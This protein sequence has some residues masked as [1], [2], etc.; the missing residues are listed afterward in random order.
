MAT[1]THSTSTEVHENNLET[2][3][4][5]WLESAMNEA[6]EYIEAQKRL[7]K[8]INHLKIFDDVEQCESYMR[9]VPKDDRIILIISDQLG[10]DIEGISTKVNALVDQIL[11]D[12]TTRFRNKVDEIL[13][14]N[15]FNSGT[16]AEK[17]TTGLNGQFV[18][19]Q[20]L[21]DRLL[22]MKP[23]VTDKNELTDRCKK[24]YKNNSSELAIIQEFEKDYVSD[25][26]LWWYT[27][28]S[29]LY[30]LLNKALR[31]QDIDLLFL[32]RF[33][34]CDIQKQ[35]Q[36]LQ[37]S[38]FLRVY[39]GQ[40][41]SKDELDTLK[42]STGQFISMNSFL[43]TSL[44]RRLAL[45][46]LSSSTI[47]D[48][49]QRILFEIDL[50]PTL[51][52]IKP[53]ADITS[54]SF[55]TNEQE[56]LI[57]LGSI[58]RLVNIDCQNGVW[59]AHMAMCSDN[60]NSLKPI[61]D[62]MKNEYDENDS[63]S[64]DFS[65]GILLFKMGQYDKA[66]KY[67]NRLLSELPRDHPDL[68]PCYHNLGMVANHKGKYDTSLEW[69]AKALE[70]YNKTRQP[71]DPVVATTYN[72]IGE[73]HFRKGNRTNALESFKKALSIRK[74]RFGEEHLQVAMCYHNMG[75]V[76]QEEK[77]F[78]EAFECHQKSLMI[79]QKYLPTDHPDIG[80]SVHCIASIYLCLNYPDLAL[81]YYNRA[82]EIYQK[83]LPSQ[84]QDIA[85]SHYNLGLL[86]AGKED[87]QQALTHFQKASTIFHVT[88]PSTHPFIGIVNQDIQRRC[89]GTA[90]A[91]WCCAWTD[92][93]VTPT[94][95]CRP[96]A[97]RWGVLTLG[98]LIGVIIGKPIKGFIDVN[99][100]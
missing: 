80:A 8:L 63:G 61:Y 34:M 98:G 26:A 29:F 2:Y 77:K 82:L 96:S 43:S 66:E 70:M 9:S 37:C 12:Q 62:Y 55:F 53:F 23:K 54:S 91:P 57:M 51:A 44:D 30:R 28:E 24:F 47:S 3:S 52:G 85:M 87:F 22:R 68:A 75:N 83:S 13:P 16:Q 41:I 74:K 50:D 38:T 21:I 56:V 17:S 65:F 88:L 95:S 4:L 93:C 5:V 14:I 100:V 6:N 46:F 39:R 25:R 69:F 32:F 27:R 42:T 99:D 72:S 76:Y 90:L 20:L 89:C 40:V 92:S 35:L 10:Q 71:D 11:L 31:T 97:R 81:Q 58:F 73:V 60:D 15:I 18:F 86:Y 78:Q 49:L 59:I 45:S 7:R 19:S 48:D 94:R 84:H 67:C 64:S 33:F 79:R 1:T 36:K